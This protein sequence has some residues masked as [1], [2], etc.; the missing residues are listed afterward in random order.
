MRQSYTDRRPAERTPLDYRARMQQL[1]ET[2]PYAFASGDARESSPI[3]RFPHNSSAAWTAVA[4]GPGARLAGTTGGNAPAALDEAFVYLTNV[5]D[6]VFPH[7]LQLLLNT[8]HQLSLVG[9]V[10]AFYGENLAALAMPRGGERGGCHARL[11]DA[12]AQHAGL[13]G[14]HDVRQPLLCA[15]RRWWRPQR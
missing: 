15:A 13:R 4:A 3:E 12:G 7:R 1:A 9:N 2:L 14:E 8:W 5:D 6:E 10:A 11:A